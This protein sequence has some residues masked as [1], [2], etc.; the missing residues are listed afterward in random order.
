MADV[1]VHEHA[2][3]LTWVVTSE[4]LRRACHALVADGRVWLVDPIDE[5]GPLARATALGAPAGVIQLLDRHNRDGVAIAARLEVPLL[6]LPASV[7]G[8]PFTTMSVL[9]VPGWREMALWWPETATLVVPEAVGTAPTFAVG[10]GS[11]GVHPMLRLFGV[12]RLR[13]IEPELLLVGHGPPVVG[14]GAAAALRDALARSRSDLPRFVAKLPG[15]VR[16]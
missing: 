5:S 16:S 15:M 9:D 12:R 8:S 11:V 4:L 6:R 3:G 13:D 14:P 7:P 10:R 2:A 1:E